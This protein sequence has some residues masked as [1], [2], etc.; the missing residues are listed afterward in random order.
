MTLPGRRLVAAA[1]GAALLLAVFAAAPRVRATVLVALSLDELV[2]NAELVFTGEVIDSRT[3][4]VNDLVYTVLRFSIDSTIA[5]SF[6]SSELEL[7][8]LGGSSGDFVTEVSGQYLPAV[9]ARGLFFVD[10]TV[11][12]LVNP[13]VGW[14][15]G[16]FPLID[17]DGQTWLDLKNHPDYGLLEPDS[18]PLAAKMRGLN[19]SREQI[20]DRFPEQFQ[21]PLED[22]AA[23]IAVMY[24]RRGE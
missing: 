4:L 23:L 15:Q 24:Q 22:F 6:E 5:G 21:Y 12:D 17:A 1:L 19:F 13:L 16:H 8:F 20:A 18:D 10:D 14:S 3:E 7:R 9:G 11:R 2:A